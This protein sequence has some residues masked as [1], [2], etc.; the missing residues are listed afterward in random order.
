ME[1][2]FHCMVHKPNGLFKISQGVK[3]A[4]TL[5]QTGFLLFTYHGFV[6]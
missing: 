1:I 4:K 3:A 5:F 2:L 6:S